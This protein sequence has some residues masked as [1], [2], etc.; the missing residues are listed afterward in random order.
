M[1]LYD[2]SSDISASQFTAF[3]RRDIVGISFE[4]STVTLP[5]K[6]LICQTF[7]IRTDLNIQSDSSKELITKT[8]ANTDQIIPKIYS[9]R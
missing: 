6:A 5:L 7:D 1:R 9:L 4:C 3:V 8:V 2:S